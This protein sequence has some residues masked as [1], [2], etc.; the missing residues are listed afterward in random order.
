MSHKENS[1]GRVSLEG[2]D[3]VH[4]RRSGRKNKRKK[5]PNQKSPA[6][7]RRQGVREG[8]PHF[9][10]NEVRRS[11]TEKAL[12]VDH[13]IRRGGKVTTR[14]KKWIRLEKAGGLKGGWKKKP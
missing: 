14:L 4:S 6:E 11:S 8:P 3:E 9:I 7:P 1:R 2:R 5:L 10:V 12:P 13:T